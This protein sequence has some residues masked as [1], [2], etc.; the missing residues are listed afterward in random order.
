MEVNVVFRVRPA[1][2]ADAAAVAG[3]HH[4]SF[5]TAYRGIMPDWYL[6]RPRDPDS[7]ERWTGI[8]TA[9]Q[10]EP[11]WPQQPEGVRTLVAEDGSGEVGGVSAIGRPRME[12]M[13]ADAELWMLYVHPSRWGSGLA[14][15][16]HRRSLDFLR[17]WGHAQA[18]LWAATDNARARR[19]YEREGWY[20]A[21]E[22]IVD[23]S[24]G[25]ALSEVRYRIDLVDRDP[26]MD[27]T[28]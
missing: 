5:L 16:L 1:E 18:M 3:V 27:P 2:P 8:L 26:R 19:F 10:A 23:D 13:Q 4:A 17:G 9:E 14:A 11:P 22:P 28:A 24:R 12:G 25:F 6:D 20:I 15:T 7:V 21:G